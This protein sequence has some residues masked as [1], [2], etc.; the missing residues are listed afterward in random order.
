MSTDRSIL[1]N[2]NSG[3]QDPFYV[4][5]YVAPFVLSS[6]RFYLLHISPLL[7]RVSRQEY[8]DARIHSSEM[9]IEFTFKVVTGCDTG[10]P[11]AS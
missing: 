4:H 1:R 2:F 5:L 3:M 11:Y 8:A 10:S 7:T 9:D 6:Q